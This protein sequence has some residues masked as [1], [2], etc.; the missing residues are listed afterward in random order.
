MFKKPKYEYR[1]FF[2]RPAPLTNLAL[3]LALR[4]L[5]DLRGDKTLEERTDRYYVTPRVNFGVKS[6]DGKELE[7]KFIVPG[8]LLSRYDLWAKRDIA[9]R[10]LNAEPPFTASDLAKISGHLNENN[11]EADV[12]ELNVERSVALVKKIFK[13]EVDIGGKN[14]DFEVTT[15][16]SPGG[17]EWVTTSVED[18]KHEQVTN[19]LNSQLVQAEALREALKAANGTAIQCSYPK[20]ALSIF[21]AN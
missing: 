5:E 14:V 13:E 17:K 19:F 10:D 11:V 18:K 9:E 7:L 16:T 12:N 20:F 4:K 21:E 1:T 15:F 8:D 3:E 2:R 6:R